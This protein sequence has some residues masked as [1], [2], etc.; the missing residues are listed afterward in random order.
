[1]KPKHLVQ[2]YL[3]GWRAGYLIETKGGKAR[4]QPIAPYK[5]VQ[6]RPIW[7]ELSLVAPVESQE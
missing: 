2:Y 6:P 4:I 5:G 3:E 1:V 7:I